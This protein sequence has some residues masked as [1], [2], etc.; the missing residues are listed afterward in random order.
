MKIR[1]ATIFKLLLCCSFLLVGILACSSNDIP[2]IITD[3][4]TPTESDTSQQP[5]DSSLTDEQSYPG[6]AADAATSAYPGDETRPNTVLGQEVL[7]DPPDPDRSLPAAAGESSV[8]GG[9]LIR[10]IQGEGFLPLN[11][12]EL[13]LA[14]I[15]TNTDGEPMLISYND[16]SVRA[17]T[18]STGIFVF[19]NVPPG[20]YALIVNLAVMEFPVRDADGT[21]LFITVEPGSTIDLG[22]V[23][24]K[25]P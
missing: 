23:F 22:Q 24:T 3:G 17:E 5:T 10:E 15:V 14:N 6:P 20:T 25:F 19:N 11:P 18:F 2:V 9:V 8:I 7:V 16:Q 1:T 12:H 4:D 13:I 21:E